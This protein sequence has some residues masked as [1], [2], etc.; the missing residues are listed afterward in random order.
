MEN[1]SHAKESR[2]PSTITR[3]KVA[4]EYERTFSRTRFV[5]NGESTVSRMRVA[6]KSE[7][8]VSQTRF[9]KNGE[10]D[11]ASN[12]KLLLAVKVSTQPKP[13]AKKRDLS[14]VYKTNKR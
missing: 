8:I 9:E 13:N 7:S 5:K 10:S 14:S 1:A 4:Q 3:T 11:N 12:V 2:Q 6:R